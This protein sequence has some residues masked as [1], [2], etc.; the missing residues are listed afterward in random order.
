MLTKC[1]KDV[2]NIP[3]GEAKDIA[4]FLMLSDEPVQLSSLTITYEEWKAVVSLYEK[5]G[6]H[7]DVIEYEEF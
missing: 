4:D 7:P 6:V 2:K 1:I 5:Q 3:L